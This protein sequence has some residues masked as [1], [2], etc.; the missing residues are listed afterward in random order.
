M[1]SEE[2]NYTLKAT[3]VKNHYDAMERQQ[4]TLLG[5]SHS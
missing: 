5:P 3:L 2:T 1:D 4:L